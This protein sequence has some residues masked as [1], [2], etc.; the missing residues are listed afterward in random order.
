VVISGAIPYQ[1]GL[2]TRFDQA[3]LASWGKGFSESRAAVLFVRGGQDSII[4]RERM[5]ASEQAFAKARPKDTFVHVEQSDG[6]S[7]LQLDGDSLLEGGWFGPS[8]KAAQSAFKARRR[9]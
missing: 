4:P 6:H 9:R 5:I 1:A 3:S 2:E 7:P 8:A